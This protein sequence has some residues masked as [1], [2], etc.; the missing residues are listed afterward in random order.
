MNVKLYT[1]DNYRENVLKSG[2]FR[3]A[4]CLDRFDKNIK[5]PH[6][7]SGKME[8]LELNNEGGK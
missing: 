3:C 6:C 1:D 5:C 7:N 2:D 4:S 8:C